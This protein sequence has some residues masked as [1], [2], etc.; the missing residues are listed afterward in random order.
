MKR[1]SSVLTEDAKTWVEMQTDHLKKW[2]EEIVVKA[3]RITKSAE[4]LEQQN[5]KNEKT[6]ARIE[7]T[8]A[9][10]EKSNEIVEKRNEILVDQLA[11]LAKHC[12]RVEGKL[13]RIEKTD[14]L[15][16]SAAEIQKEA[17]NFIY[18]VHGYPADDCEQETATRL[19]RKARKVRHSYRD[20]RKICEAISG[21][22]SEDTIG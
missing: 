17:T 15:Y 6:A 8:A 21:G 4:L 16:H 11:V 18:R 5:E 20:H 3:T 2:S 7:K 1:S 9:T 12:R 10:L 19:L 13:A 22:S 14:N